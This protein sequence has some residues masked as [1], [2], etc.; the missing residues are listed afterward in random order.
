MELHWLP[1]HQRIDF[2]VLLFVYKTQ[3][4]LAPLYISDCLSR[5]VPNCRLRSSNANLYTL[6]QY[7]VNHIRSGASFSHHA[8]KIWNEVKEATSIHIFKS[9]VKTYSTFLKLLISTTILC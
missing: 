1:V 7:T 9:Q 6:A 2:K 4:N 3:H 5:Y 8:P